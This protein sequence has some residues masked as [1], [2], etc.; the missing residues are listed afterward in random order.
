[1]AGQTQG[2]PLRA[3]LTALTLSAAFGA[4][5][6]VLATADYSSLVARMPALPSR[7]SSQTACAP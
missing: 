4:L 3:S 1:M 5:I 7:I 6:A 2:S